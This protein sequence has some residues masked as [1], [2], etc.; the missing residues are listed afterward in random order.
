MCFFFPSFFLFCY[1][2]C[3]VFLKAWEK[4]IYGNHIPSVTLR[5]V[6]YYTLPLLN[7]ENFSPSLSLQSYL[8]CAVREAESNSEKSIYTLP[9]PTIC[10]SI[11]QPP[12]SHTHMHTHK[13]WSTETPRKQTGLWLEEPDRSWLAPTNPLSELALHINNTNTTILPIPVPSILCHQ[14]PSHSPPPPPPIPPACTPPL[15]I[16]WNK[17]PKPPKRNCIKL[18]NW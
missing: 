5:S 10:L 14:T 17:T 1:F 15:L 13:L 6:H 2:F 16:F 3:F 9:L 8:N 12:N 4:W 7:P 18:R 11:L